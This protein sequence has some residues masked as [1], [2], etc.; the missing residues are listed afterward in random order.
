MTKLLEN[1]FRSVNIAL[2]NELAVL[3]EHMDIDLWEVVDA[4]ATKPFGFMPFRPGPG[5]G[6]HCIPI[7]PYY[8]AWKAREYD[9][10]TR[11][12]E[13]AADI[14]QAMP[15]HVVGL[16]GRAL[17]RAGVTVS[18]ARIL[19]L[20]VAF[21]ADVDDP[22]NSPAERVIELLMNR[23][24]DVRYHDPYIPEFRIGENVFCRRLA[25]LQSVE[26]TDEQLR[27]ADAVV[28]LAGHRAVD[29]A[30]V[31]AIA[32]LVVDTANAT[33][34]LDGP[35]VRLGSPLPAELEKARPVTA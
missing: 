16:I 9:F 34:G 33:R 22:R 17:D 24:A 26:L 5:V 13:L 2:V 11:F 1:I 27:G 21:K 3:A 29:Y 15:R 35:I 23:G 25:V 4:A 28:I 19:V 18:G 30:R 14:N 10:S 32:P 31:A 6:G 7:D 12:I 8:L 20:G